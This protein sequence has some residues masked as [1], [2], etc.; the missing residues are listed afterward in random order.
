[1]KR[2]E[3]TVNLLDEYLET[4]KGMKEAETPPFFYTR[5]SAR[6]Q[7]QQDWA[8]PLKPAWLVAGL[9]VLLAVNAGIVIS[10]YTQPLQNNVTGNTSLQNFASG[11]DLT[12]QSTY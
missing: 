10:R 4:V 12:V 8:L 7:K 1:M 2:K 3:T 11:Y 9:L 5:L 6:I